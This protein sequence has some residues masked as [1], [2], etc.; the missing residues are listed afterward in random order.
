MVN[1][2]GEPGHKDDHGGGHVDGDDVERE[3][4][5]KDEVHL[6]AAV[7][8][9]KQKGVIQQWKVVLTSGRLSSLVVGFPY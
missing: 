7:L 9:W 3:L 2:E 1:P 5:G 6:E 4:P 8:P